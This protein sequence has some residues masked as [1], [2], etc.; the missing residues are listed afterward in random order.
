M[1]SR[2]FPIRVG[3]P[4]RWTAVSSSLGV[5][6]HPGDGVS[7]QLAIRVGSAPAAELPFPGDVHPRVAGSTSDRSQ[8]DRPL[9]WHLTADAEHKCLPTEN[10]E[11]Y[12]LWG[13]PSR[14]NR[15][16][17][18]ITLHYARHR[19]DGL[20]YRPSDEPLAAKPSCFPRTCACTPPSRPRSCI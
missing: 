20:Q 9:D 14:S 15:M 11:G 19:T 8:W 13:Q 7:V 12:P 6:E 5:S 2:P 3:S 16:A 18:L 4:N 17:K 1:R 10:G